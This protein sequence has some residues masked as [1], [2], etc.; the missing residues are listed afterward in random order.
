MTAHLQL[1]AKQLAHLQRMREYL[2]HLAWRRGQKRLDVY[3]NDPHNL[4]R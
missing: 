2:G 4:A 1:I 3:T